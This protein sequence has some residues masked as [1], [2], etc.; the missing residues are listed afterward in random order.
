MCI[1]DSAE[2]H[3]DDVVL[4]DGLPRIQKDGRARPLR[5]AAARAAHCCGFVEGAAADVAA[6]GRG[7]PADA[8]A[9]AAGAGRSRGAGV[10]ADARRAA[11]RTR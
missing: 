6:Q 11:R 8:D 10:L 7:G 1:R 3:G 2:E 9:G 4:E 5:R